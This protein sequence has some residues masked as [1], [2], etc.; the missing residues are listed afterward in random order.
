MATLMGGIG[1]HYDPDRESLCRDIRRSQTPKE[2][3]PTGFMEY[4]SNITEGK[5]MI[6]LS[7][8]TT[9]EYI[10]GYHNYATGMVHTGDMKFT[11]EEDARKYC[12]EINANASDNISKLG[13]Y[14]YIENIKK[15]D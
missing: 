8:N 10:V 14:V 1:G 9:V 5:V 4:M 12:E 7:P 6:P 15:E 13:R 11:N 3:E 2:S